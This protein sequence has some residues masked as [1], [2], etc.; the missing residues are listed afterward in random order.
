[1]REALPFLVIALILLNLTAFAQEKNIVKKNSS[2]LALDSLST[3]KAGVS[4]NPLYY[5]FTV[6]QGVIC[7]KEYQL[8]KR[9]GL[10]LRFRLGSLA[11]VDRLERKPNAVKE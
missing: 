8:E 5:Q 10:P 4:L 9:T 11:Y 7:R 3:P 1:M 2:L 6:Q